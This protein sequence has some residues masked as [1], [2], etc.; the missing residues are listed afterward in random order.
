MNKKIFQFILLF[1]FTQVNAQIEEWQ[2]SSWV[3]EHPGKP[4]WIPAEESGE[5]WIY[6]INTSLLGDQFIYCG[7]T[8]FPGVT[9]DNFYGNELPK[10]VDICELSTENNWKGYAWTMIGNISSI[11]PAAGSKHSNSAIYCSGEL[12]NLIPTSDGGIIAVGRTSAT[13]ASGANSENNYNAGIGLPGNKSAFGCDKDRP[14]YYNPNSIFQYPIFNHVEMGKWS[15][16]IKGNMRHAIA[17]KLSKS[18]F[19][20][21][22]DGSLPE[23]IFLNKEPE[24]IHLYGEVE[25]LNHL[26]EREKVY[27]VGSEFYAV[28]E[29]DNGNFIFVGRAGA[30]HSDG[31]NQK[32]FIVETDAQGY[33]IW[34]RSYPNLDKF[35]NTLTEGLVIYNNDIY[36]SGIKYD[37]PKETYRDVVFLS[38]INGSTHDIEWTR[39]TDEFAWT[40][41]FT[42]DDD[43]VSVNQK[44]NNSLVLNLNNEL[45]MPI[46]FDCTGNF[47]EGD[48]QNSYVFRLNTSNGDIIGTT[49]FGKIAAYDLKIG[50]TPT[51]DGGF[52]VTTTK[53]L[54]HKDDNYPYAFG[55]NSGISKKDRTRSDAFLAKCNSEGQIEWCTTVDSDTDVATDFSVIDYSKDY[56]KQECLYASIETPDGGLIIA[57]NNSN[58][59]D[60][61]YV[62]KF[63]NQCDPVKLNDHKVGVEMTFIGREIHLGEYISNN[64]L[65]FETY[66]D[67]NLLIEAGD[68]II[69]KP[70]TKLASGT[71][72]ILRIDQDYSCTI[73]SPPIYFKNYNIEDNNKDNSSSFKIDFTS[74]KDRL[75]AYYTADKEYETVLRIFD[76]NGKQ[77]FKQRNLATDLFVEQVDIS[78]LLSGVYFIQIVENGG[79]TYSQKFLR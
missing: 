49:E 77:V 55:C 47:A 1:T 66:Q 16:G 69:I 78:G 12:F 22:P 40:N 43:F 60:D 23:S 4:G 30:T 44:R 42:G 25:L 62:V 19:T 45:L 14:M 71:N 50:I 31:F 37:G 64:D 74:Y 29:K 34:K 2:Q 56:K 41:G 32:T 39:T 70:G 28:H 10:E 46:G 9:Y 18:D 73:P 35:T 79:K 51:T 8:T 6:D 5:D 11:N 54:Y 75:I 38:K 68:A 65:F 20:P 33:V 58:N 24:W 15:S 57:G 61:N 76:L 13:W 59:F 17:I 67:A 36:I 21:N 53:R 27:E 48:C 63:S 3:H 52:A 7:Y 72:V 26:H